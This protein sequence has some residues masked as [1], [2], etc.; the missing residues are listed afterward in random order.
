MAQ[1]KISTTTGRRP[2]APPSQVMVRLFTENLE[3]GESLSPDSSPRLGPEGIELYKKFLAPNPPAHSQFL[4]DVKM[5]IDYYQPF[6]SNGAPNFWPDFWGTEEAWHRRKE[7]LRE[8]TAHYYVACVT[9]EDAPLLNYCREIA[10]T[11]E[12]LVLSFYRWNFLSDCTALLK[13]YMC[14]SELTINLLPFKDDKNTLQVKYLSIKCQLVLVKRR[15]LTL[16]DTLNASS[17]YH[18]VQAKITTYLQELD[19]KQKEIERLRQEKAAAEKSAAPKRR[20]ELKT[21]SGE[22]S[23]VE[24]LR[25]RVEELEEQLE[26]AQAEN[27]LLSDQNTLLVAQLSEFLERESKEKQIPE[28]ESDHPEDLQEQCARLK[29]ELKEAKAELARKETELNELRDN[30]P[31]EVTHDLG[32]ESYVVT[33]SQAAKRSN[34]L[35]F[36]SQALLHRLQGSDFRLSDSASSEPANRY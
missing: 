13:R 34:S 10:S 18:A 31:I 1:D 2:I 5:L 22:E 29:A 26:E 6:Y 3:A 27:R 8:L 15:M 12:N 23:E 16:R 20:L 35:F 24:Q 9:C 28:L 33:F 30:S 4:K 17:D 25:R 32:D 36:R 19:N 14:N 7:Q 21:S 11:N